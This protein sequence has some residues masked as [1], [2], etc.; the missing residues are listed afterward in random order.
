[1]YRQDK[2][3]EMMD[4]KLRIFVEYSKRLPYIYEIIENL[5][6]DIAYFG[7]PKESIY[8]K[9]DKFY[10]VGIDDELLSLMVK[11][12]KLEKEYYEE[13]L[14]IKSVSEV[15]TKLNPVEIELLYLRYERQ[16]TFRNI[17]YLKHYSYMNIARDIDNILY[18]F[19]DYN[20]S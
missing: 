18:K 7:Y 2:D 3:L 17:G 12:D 5:K 9:S 1:M 8:K 20:N 15:L 4:L 13:L 11:R 6:D 16:M 14:L 10:F 19:I